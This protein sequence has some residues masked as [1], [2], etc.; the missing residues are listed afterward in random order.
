MSPEQKAFLDH[1]RKVIGTMSDEEVAILVRGISDRA[2]I[3][4]YEHGKVDGLAQGLKT[5]AEVAREQIARLTA[6]RDSLQ[7]KY[8]GLANMMGAGKTRQ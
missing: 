2:A 8:D 6:E 3:R 5:G 1:V 7:T 4:G